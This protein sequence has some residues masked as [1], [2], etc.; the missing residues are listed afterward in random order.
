MRERKHGTL[1]IQTIF[2]GYRARKLYEEERHRKKEGPRVTQVYKRAHKISG[3]M[4]VL[5]V[6]K[7]GDSYKFVGENLH[8]LETYKGSIGGE[9][10]RALISPPKS[11]ESVEVDLNEMVRKS[12]TRSSPIV[13][14]SLA[15]GWEGTNARRF[16]ADKVFMKKEDD[17]HGSIWLLPDRE[18]GGH[19]IFD[20]GQIMSVTAFSF[21]N[22]HNAHFNDRGTKHFQVQVSTDMKTYTTVCEGGLTKVWSYGEKIPWETFKCNKGGHPARYVKFVADT[23]YGKGGGLNSMRVFRAR[24][25]SNSKKLRLLVS[26]LPKVS[27][28]IHILLCCFSRHER[29]PPTSKCML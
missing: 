14:E 24:E 5:T 21:K 8:L 6:Y 18:K 25:V 23:F 17:N 9:Q 26:F 10:V 15:F 20:L 1:V 12:T 29:P 19:F 4:I 7:C 2:R 22:T 28:C 13:T 16:S 3:F 27:Y 11:G